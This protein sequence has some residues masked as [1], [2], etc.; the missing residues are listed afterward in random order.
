[1]PRVPRLGTLPDCKYWRGYL[2]AFY[3]WRPILVLLRTLEASPPI[4]RDDKR[5]DGNAG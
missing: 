3:R 2:Y 1:M 4:V 5:P